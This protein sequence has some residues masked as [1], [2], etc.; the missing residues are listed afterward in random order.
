MPRLLG[1][2]V[3]P[4]SVQQRRES[5]RER[6]QDVRE[7][8]RRRRAQTVP[9][10]NIIGQIESQVTS[11][12]NNVISRDGVMSR[13]RDVRGSDSGTSEEQTEESNGPSRGRTGENSVNV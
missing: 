3:L 6:L 9:G 1:E 8:I 7:P 2:N 11:L 4:D 13:I 5:V 10:P 12:R